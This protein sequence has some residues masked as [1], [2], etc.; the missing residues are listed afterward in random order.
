MAVTIQEPASIPGSSITPENAN[1]YH[2]LVYEQ[3][4]DDAGI[5]RLRIS[6][7][8]NYLGFNTHKVDNLESYT[9]MDPNFPWDSDADI[10]YDFD[11][12]GKPDLTKRIE[13]LKDKLG[14]SYNDGVISETINAKL[15]RIEQQ[16]NGNPVTTPTTSSTGIQADLNQAIIDL[17]SL[18]EEVGSA[19]G[20]SGTLTERIGTLEQAVNGDGSTT[21][22]RPEVNILNT[23]IFGDSSLPQP[24]GLQVDVGALQNDVTALNIAV[25]IPYSGSDSLANRTDAL[26]T[27]VGNETITDGSISANINTIKGDISDIRSS[28]TN[29]YTYQGDIYD[30][31]GD[32]THKTTW[33]DTSFDVAMPNH[34]LLSDLETGW[35][36][37]INV[38][39]GNTLKIYTD[40]S[41]SFVEYTNGTNI[42]WIKDTTQ[43]N[44][45]GKFDEL[46][47]AIDVSEVNTL[48][49]KVT[50]LESK[51]K[52]EDV[53]AGNTWS[54]SSMINIPGI[55]T[56]STLIPAS[57]SNP[58]VLCAFTAAIDSS[59][60]ISGT[61]ADC[62]G[63]FSTYFQIDSSNFVKAKVQ[64]IR[65]MNYT[66]IG[67][68]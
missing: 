3:A 32:A 42:S 43:P 45:W 41:G 11:T 46:G 53:T 66:K 35:V 24:N 63:N 57:G 2:V 9:G 58:S 17:H 1:R 29:L 52:T 7:W 49:D 56:F 54:S 12:Y 59:G 64:S 68:I 33:I 8:K 6:D 4:Q 60:M 14:V 25:G 18:E 50:T 5:K 48:K 62:S 47:S 26:E 61:P 21:G 16:I 44:G 55:Y 39:Q 30:I 40:D 19:S 23:T 28:I 13:N 65:K 37:N 34:I 36:Y 10:D 67:E 31:D 27:K 38:G 51:F 22:L 15:N 20:G